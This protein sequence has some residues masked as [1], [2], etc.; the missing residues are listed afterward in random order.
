MNDIGSDQLTPTE[1]RT[2]IVVIVIGL[3]LMAFVMLVMK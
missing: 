2:V 3:A 1:V